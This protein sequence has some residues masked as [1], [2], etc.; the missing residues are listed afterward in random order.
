MI[1]FKSNMISTLVYKINS[2]V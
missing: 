2:R 1:T